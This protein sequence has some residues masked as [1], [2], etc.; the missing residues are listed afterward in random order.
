[1]NYNG[2]EQCYSE[3]GI[4]LYLGDCMKL[5][6]QTSDKYYD[7][8]ICDPPYGIGWE[9]MQS[10]WGEGKIVANNWKRKFNKYK[11]AEW[12]IPPS[13]E[14]FGELFRISDNQIIWGA[15]HFSLPPTKSMIFWDKQTGDFS[16]GDGELAW[17]SIGGSIRKF[18][19][20]WSGMRK[21]PNGN[22]RESRI[23]PTQKPVALY[24]WVLQNYAKPGDT[25]LDTHLGSGSSAI[26]AWE[27]GYTFT[28]IEIDADYYA[29][30]VE[31]IR[32]KLTQPYLP[33][34]M[35]KETIMQPTLI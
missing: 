1:M 28:G 27:M 25:I 29:A 16:F 32:K 14:Y 33:G 30:A 10:E 21:G 13:D 18:V 8:C 12:D 17:S 31:R 34:I 24:R 20:M 9:A 11:R 5:L 4:T 19:Y 26:A 22:V 7:L 2:F 6:E 23:H 35:L 15:N 3:G